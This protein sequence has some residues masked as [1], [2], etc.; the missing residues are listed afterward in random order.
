[1]E[2]HK[3]LLPLIPLIPLIPEHRLSPAQ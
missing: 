2:I 1:L 3:E